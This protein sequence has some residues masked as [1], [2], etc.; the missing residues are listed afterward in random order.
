MDPSVAGPDPLDDVIDRLAQHGVR[1]FAGGTGHRLDVPPPIASLLLD[2]ARSPS[3]RLRAALA[4]LLPRHPEYAP[5]AEAVALDL[6]LGDP[7][8]ETL[9]LSVVAAAALQAEWGFSLDIYL[10]SSPRIDAGRL[11]GELRLPAP[12]EDFGRPCLQAASARLAANDNFP[13]DY[14]G[15]WRHAARRLLSQLGRDALRDS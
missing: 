4:A 7:A 2:L 8:R 13:T 12:K 1:Y 15:D 14:T 3:A 5:T 11:C 10:P 9:L 6:P